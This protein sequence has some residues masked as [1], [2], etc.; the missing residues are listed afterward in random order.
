MKVLIAI[1]PEKFRDEEFA[2]PIDALQKAGIAFDIASTRRGTCVGMFGART[3]ATLSFE[4]VEPEQ[5][6]G[7]VIVGG[8]GSQV[9]LWNDEMLVHLAKFFHKSGKVIAAICLAPVVLARAGVLKGKKATYFENHASD[10]E[11]KKGGTII[12]KDPVVTDGRVITANGPLTAKE[13]GAAVVNNLTAP[14]W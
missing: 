7:L 6:D 12:M 1:A 13:F 4:E 14:G 11:M 8:P 9:H 10:F 2:E 3:T 5:Y